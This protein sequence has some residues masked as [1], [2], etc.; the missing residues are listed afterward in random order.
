MLGFETYTGAVKEYKGKPVELRHNEE[1]AYGTCDES[2]TTM[3]EGAVYS[4]R[5]NQER[6]DEAKEL[7]K[8]MQ[9]QAETKFKSTKTKPITVLI[10]VFDSLSRRH[11][12]RKLPQTQGFLN[13]L[14][15]EKF[16]VFDYKI[17]NVMGDNSLPNVYPVW[18]G[19]SLMSMSTKE[20]Y[21]NKVKMQDLIGAD[22]I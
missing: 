3:L 1:W 20:R 10:L 18:T 6:L 22:S 7:M 13:K 11:F 16:S 8:K 9:E 14:D 17:H 19:K 21:D 12:Y 4:H 2:K 15:S 5:V